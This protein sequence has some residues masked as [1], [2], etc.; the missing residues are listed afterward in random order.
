MRNT[1]APWRRRSK[2][3]IA[4]AWLAISCARPPAAQFGTGLPR[5]TAN[6]E[7][8]SLER[9]MFERLNRDR[10][11]HGLYPLEYDERLA[12]IARYHSTDMRDHHFFDHHS[13]ISGGP[14][15]RLNRASYLF[16]T[17]RENLSEAPDV[18]SSEDG[19]LNSPHHFANIMSQDI[20]H[21]GV[22]IVH[23]A[24]ISKDN[25]L[26]TQLFARPSK[27]EDL[28]VALSTIV[29]TINEQRRT[30]HLGAISRSSFLDDL[31]H[32]HIAEVNPL[33]SGGS[34]QRVAKAISEEVSAA[35]NSGF[36]SVGLSTQLL[37]DSSGFSVPP[38]LTEQS[39][40]LGIAVRNAPNEAGRPMLHVLLLAGSR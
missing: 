27:S 11:A 17:A 13:K 40:H 8:H 5:V 12:E 19:L 4:C 20:T 9:A 39:V 22:G 2:T 23:G 35:R 7:V 16:L 6:A 18:Q 28:S 30:A 36:A 25:L 10:K 33:D 24:V 21:V 14:E 29:R 38:A 15:D 3:L 37:A 32:R 34:L 26:V 31:A 1:A